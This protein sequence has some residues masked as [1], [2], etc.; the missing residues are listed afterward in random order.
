MIYADSI[1]VC[2][3]WLM[4][5]GSIINVRP[6][7]KTPQRLKTGLRQPVLCG[8]L[9]ILFI[10]FRDSFDFRNQTTSSPSSYLKKQLKTQNLRFQFFEKFENQS[11]HG[12]LRFSKDWWWFPWKKYSKGMAVK[13][14]ILKPNSLNF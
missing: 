13:E 12:F 8:S 10:T 4:L 3:G 1:R 14:R 11:I 2:A 7:S 6:N 5:I 9:N